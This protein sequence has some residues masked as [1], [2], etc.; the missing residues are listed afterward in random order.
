MDKQTIID[1]ANRACA[2]A[3]EQT[4]E[5]YRGYIID[6]PQK[7]KLYND[8]FW[9]RLPY[10]QIAGRIMWMNDECAEH[11]DKPRISPAR[12][13]EFGDRIILE[14]TVTCWRGEAT[15]ISQV[16]IGG[17]N[18]DATNPF[19]N[20]DTSAVGRALGFLG[21]GDFRGIASAEEVQSAQD[22]QGEDRPTPDMSRPRQSGATEKQ[23]NFI[24]SLAEEMQWAPGETEAFLDQIEN[25]KEGSQA[26]EA[27]KDR[28]DPRQGSL[29][30][31]TGGE[32]TEMREMDR[33]AFFA[34]IGKVGRWKDYQDKVRA[35]IA[36]QGWGTEDAPG[37]TRY[38]N[39]MQRQAVLGFIAQLP[40]PGLGA[41]FGRN[42]N[43]ALNPVWQKITQA[44]MAADIKAWDLA[45]WLMH[46]YGD[47]EPDAKSPADFSEEMV[48]TIEVDIEKAGEIMFDDIKDYVFQLKTF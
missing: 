44:A 5:K 36:E 45:A 23:K 46:E 26:I 3:R 14:K 32:R 10:M 42:E 15:G 34:E 16:F 48:K 22:R 6:I 37:T 35:Y 41:L 27:M 1:E 29:P 13:M 31:A 11:G 19:E 40:G 20:A 39:H 33:K 7:K 17:R 9:I 21:Y 4:P 12:I 25:A 2:I 24:R 30:K 28:Q 8:E 43:G 38:L 18:A 47:N